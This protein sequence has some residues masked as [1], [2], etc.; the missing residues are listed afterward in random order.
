[1]EQ[2]LAEVGQLTQQVKDLVG[3]HKSGGYAKG[4]ATE[5]EIIQRAS[6]A[7]AQQGF[8][9]ASLRGIARSAGVDH[10]TLIHHF[11]TKAKLLLAVVAW[12]DNQV[13]GQELEGPLTA[14]KIADALIGRAR[15]NQKFPG[16]VQLHSQLSVEAISPEHPAHE[17]MQRRHEILV[18][19]ISGVIQT[20][21]DAGAVADTGLSPQI[22]AA[23]IIST[24]DGLQI[25]DALHPG[26]I[27]VP[28]LMQRVFYDAFGIL[29]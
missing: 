2:L 18:K 22:Q 1:M 14:R 16:L 13:S 10:S 3:A 4:R 5:A 6:E 9:G 8:Y 11:G 28:A 15:F 7:F 26:E 12:H 17:Y 19:L 27:D 20:Q 23:M 25:Y 24:W 29:G 21:Q